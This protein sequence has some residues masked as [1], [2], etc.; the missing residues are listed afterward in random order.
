MKEAADSYK[1][2]VAEREKMIEEIDARLTALAA[3]CTKAKKSYDDAC[4]SLDK[5]RID[6]QSGRQTFRQSTKN[7]YK[8]LNLCLN[9]FN[10]MS[11]VVN[12]TQ[13]VLALKGFLF[14][15]LAP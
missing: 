9:A 8:F 4:L 7:L 14:G 2:L 3:H 12:I 13:T 15:L 5:A 1:S 11:K 6:K 10:M